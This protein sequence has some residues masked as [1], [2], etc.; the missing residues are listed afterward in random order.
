MKEIK[1]RASQEMTMQDMAKDIYGGLENRF[2]NMGSKLRD[3]G[4]LE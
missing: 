1:T 3:Q 4:I 2:L